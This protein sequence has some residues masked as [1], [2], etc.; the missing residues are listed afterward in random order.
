MGTQNGDLGLRQGGQ[1]E[2]LATQ[3]AEQ[4]DVVWHLDTER[5]GQKEQRTHPG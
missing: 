3:E 2:E 1:V 5:E 4:P